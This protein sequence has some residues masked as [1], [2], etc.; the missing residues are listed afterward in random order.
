MQI[1]AF[2]PTYKKQLE[3][4]KQQDIQNLNSQNWS[5]RKDLNST[6]WTEP[7][8]GTYASWG[9]G[10]GFIVGFFVC[11]GVCVDSGAGSAFGTWVLC[12]IISGVFGLILSAIAVGAYNSNINSIEQRIAQND[13]ATE[14]DI[15]NRNIYYEHQYNLYF[16]AFEKEAQRQ[17][18]RY[19]D[20]NLAQEII[21]WITDGFCDT[22]NAAD[23]R[24][25]IEKINVPFMFNIFQHKITCN[26]GTYDFEIKRCRNLQN[27]LEQT[28]IARAIASSIQTNIIMKYPKDES[29]TDISISLVYSYYD[30]HVT[31]TITYIAPNGNYQAV[32]E[33]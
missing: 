10:A 4:K 2:P 25:H 15:S 1:Q 28:A 21:K 20:S 8:V 33:W 24:T 29:G 14:T 18:V 12:T 9:F 5:Y 27:P 11:C 31:A 19:A 30:D 26:L 16:A 32:K 17:S 13:A 23:R 3:D 22:I 6:R 7:N